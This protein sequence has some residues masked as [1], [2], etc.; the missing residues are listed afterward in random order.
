MGAVLKID[1][2]ALSEI[3]GFSGTRLFE[4]K[5]RKADLLELI[6]K[7]IPQGA[8]I[9]DVGCANGDIAVELALRGYVVHGIDFEPERLG[10]AKRLAVEY[11]VDVEF[12]NSS[13]DE[14]NDSAC[15][16]GIIM[17]EVLEHFCEPREILQKIKRL[18]AKEGNV[19][20]TAPNMPCLS[21]R[22]KFGLLGVFPDNNPEHKYYFDRRRFCELIEGTGF[23][24]R[25]FATRYANFQPFWL[26]LTIIENVLFGWFPK[27]FSD[28]GNTLFAVLIND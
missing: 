18:L 1:N 8:R 6:E 17:G 3:T 12:T 7:Y 11:G 21:N 2:N 25:Y 20:I 19:V 5:R 23:K 24:I 27:V 10:R 14:F 22:L 13:F 28:S 16:D 4:H 9:L 15:F 26:P